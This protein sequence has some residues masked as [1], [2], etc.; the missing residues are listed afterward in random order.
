MINIIVLLIV[1][2]PTFFIIIKWAINRWNKIDQ[3]DKEGLV[4]DKLHE[5]E[6]VND[7]HGKVSD[8]DLDDFNEKKEEI[9]KVIKS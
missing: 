1:L 4:D 7:L 6:F 9:D 2:I 3:E 8:V 5:V